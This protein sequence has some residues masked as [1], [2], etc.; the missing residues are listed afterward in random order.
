MIRLMR[1]VTWS[2]FSKHDKLQA[3]FIGSL[4]LRIKKL[5]LTN[6]RRFKTFEIDFHSSL[7]VMVARNGAGKTSI[8]DGLA[9]CLG[10]FLTGLP[11]VKGS[12]SKSTDYRVESDGS[13]PPYMRLH[14]QLT[15]GVAWD[16]T[17][18]RD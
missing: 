2:L 5:A 11:G 18:V 9:I 17:V 10:A 3:T 12:S 4:F 14:C 13:R 16:R 6:F 8:L 7:T 15:N 1:N